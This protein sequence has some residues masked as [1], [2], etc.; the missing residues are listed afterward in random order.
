[1]NK[2]QAGNVYHVEIKVMVKLDKTQLD[3]TQLDETQLGITQ[4]GISY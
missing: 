1:M 4:L 2:F 3:E